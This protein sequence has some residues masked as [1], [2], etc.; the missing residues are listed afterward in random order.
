MTI[1][2]SACLLGFNCRY[3]GKNNLC[4]GLREVLS[5]HVTVAVCPEVM[6]GL[7]VPRV[8]SEIA[9]GRVV[10][11]DGRDV[12]DAFRLGAE[13]ITQALDLARVDLAVLKARSPSCGRDAVYD[14]TFSHTLTQGHGVFARRL[15]DAGVEVVTEKTAVQRIR[16]M[17]ESRGETF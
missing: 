12:D 9:K 6:G 3:D 7:P 8:P 16:E 4:P 2:V 5:H 1:L 15:L 13:R 11:R 14:G 10:S 17:E